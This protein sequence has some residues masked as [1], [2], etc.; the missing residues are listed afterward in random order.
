MTL[1]VISHSRHVSQNVITRSEVGKSH[2]VQLVFLSLRSQ[3]P[4]HSP[5]AQKNVPHIGLKHR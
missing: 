1:R 4:D 3:L 5:A 2:H